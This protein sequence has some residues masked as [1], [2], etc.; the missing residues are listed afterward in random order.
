VRNT[1]YSGEESEHIY[2]LE[3]FK[4]ITIYFETENGYFNGSGSK[5]IYFYNIYDENKKYGW[6]GDNLTFVGNPYS[7]L[8]I[9]RY[10]Y[11]VNINDYN[12]FIINNGGDTIKFSNW[13]ITPEYQNRLFQGVY[14]NGYKTRLNPDITHVDDG[15]GTDNQLVIDVTIDAAGSWPHYS[16]RNTSVTTEGNGS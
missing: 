5:K 10:K 9:C 2:K 13:T 16:E 8:A 11:T 4:D 15:T 14:E 7:N 12:T 3:H 6:P 1:A